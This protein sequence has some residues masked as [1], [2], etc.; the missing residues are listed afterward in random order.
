M[1]EGM[2]IAAQNIKAHQ[3]KTARLVEQKANH[4]SIAHWMEAAMLRCIADVKKT[5][6]SPHEPPMPRLAG[7]PHKCSDSRS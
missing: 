5:C 2:A 4:N 6:T 1:K 3:E 7:V